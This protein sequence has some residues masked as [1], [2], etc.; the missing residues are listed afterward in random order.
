[1]KRIISMLLTILLTLS[2]TSVISF[3]ATDNS[4]SAEVFVSISA[5]KDKLDMAY[6]PVNVN[7]IDGD[8]VL[9]INDALFCAHDLAFVGGAKNGYESSFSQWGLSLVKLWGIENGGSFGYYVNNISAW[10]LADPVK[11][12]DHVYAFVYADTMFFSDEYS[13]FA[14]T[15][16]TVK[17]GEKIEISLKKLGY[18]AMWELEESTVENA[19]I[20]VDGKTTDV[21]TDS[22]GNAVIVITKAGTHIISAVSPDGTIITAPVCKVKVNRDFISLIMYY[23]NLI[24]SRIVALLTK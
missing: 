5:S 7:D 20:T 11:D 3:A 24:V 21:K 1:M 16:K 8:G 18:N 12:G 2:M 23:I 14:E 15:E 4:A 19:V 10:S 17:Q 9:T 22:E 13:F 6:V